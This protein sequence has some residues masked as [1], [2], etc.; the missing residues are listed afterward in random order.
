MGFDISFDVSLDPD[1]VSGDV[2]AELPNPKEEPSIGL[3]VDMVI[4]HLEGILDP[5]QTI[6]RQRLVTRP[7]KDV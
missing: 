5:R 2:L 7:N 4:Q 3:C 6:S 1:S